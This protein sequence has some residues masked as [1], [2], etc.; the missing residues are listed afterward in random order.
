MPSKPTKW[1]K[2][3]AV[4]WAWLFLSAHW[5]WRETAPWTWK[6]RISVKFNIYLNSCICLKYENINIGNEG[7][8][9]M[10]EFLKSCISKWENRRRMNWPPPKKYT[11]LPHPFIGQPHYWHQ[12]YFNLSQKP[13]ISKFHHSP[14]V[15]VNDY[16]IFKLLC[17][18]TF[19]LKS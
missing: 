13:K 4:S 3:K 1:I 10:I 19:F 7:K 8:A 17:A 18:Q 14:Y 11:P 9:K 15:Y 2:K 5:G 6:F 12:K 16:Y